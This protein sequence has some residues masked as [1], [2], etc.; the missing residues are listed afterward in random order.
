MSRGSTLSIQGLYG[1]DPSLFDDMRVPEGLVRD[2]L[3]DT[4]LVRSSGFEALYPDW[5]YMRKA[6]GLWSRS[7]AKGFDRIAATMDLS[8][9]PIDNFDRHEEWTEDS[10]GKASSKSGGTSTDNVSAYNEPGDLV[11]QSQTDIEGKESGDHE[12]TVHHV[13][14]LRGNIG[15]TTTQHMITEERDVARFDVYA[16][17]ADDFCREFCIMVY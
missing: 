10:R 15:V 8:Y 1:W 5:G 7:R 9:N 17:V 14:R 16:Y 6:I 13:G 11:K 4:I 2:T 3:I 12:D